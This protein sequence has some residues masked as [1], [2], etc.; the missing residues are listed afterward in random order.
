MI[1]NPRGKK[2]RIFLPSPLVDSTWT[3]LKTPTPIMDSGQWVQL[4]QIEEVSLQNFQIRIPRLRILPFL[5][6][7]NLFAILMSNVLIVISK[8]ISRRIE[9]CQINILILPLNATALKI[10]SGH[11]CPVIGIHKA[12]SLCHGAHLCT[13]TP[14][15]L[16]VTPTPSPTWTTSLNPCCGPLLEIFT[17]LKKI[18][19]TNTLL[20]DLPHQLFM[21]EHT[22]GTP[23]SEQMRKFALTL[24]LY[25]PKAYEYA[26][27]ILPL[28]S[29]RTL[30]KW[31]HELYFF[32]NLKQTDSLKNTYLSH[33][34][35]SG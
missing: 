35:D 31:V 20:A 25:G 29:T 22:S 16:S 24:H 12:F 33:V 32:F 27:S 28:P 34:L 17:Q 7:Q 13:V 10:K 30:R 21:K 1:H 9:Y 18:M 26:S 8:L 2:I 14:R 15:V 19:E 6:V 11:I 5:K 4:S 3:P 23:Y